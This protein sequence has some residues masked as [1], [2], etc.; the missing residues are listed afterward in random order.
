MFTIIT[1]KDGEIQIIDSE[2]NRPLRAKKRR[3]PVKHN[4]GKAGQLKK[5]AQDHNEAN[6]CS[7]RAFVVL[8]GI[9]YGEAL[10][11][12]Y[13]A[14][15]K[16]RQGTYVWQ[17]NEM[18]NKAGFERTELNIQEAIDALAEK[19]NYKVKNLTTR[20]L[21][22]FPDV[23]EE[24]GWTN[25]R[26]WVNGHCLAF[27]DGIVHDWAGARAKRIYNAQQMTKKES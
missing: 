20:Q 3:K 14:G 10:K 25:V 2:T 6:D 22:M 19:K 21:A 15:R 24:L 9:Q 17:E 5:F 8:T 18:A 12:S 4:D 23:F 26:V 16:P 27:K 13:D 11:M 7:I 1:D